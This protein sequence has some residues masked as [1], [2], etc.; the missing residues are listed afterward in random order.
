MSDSGFSLEMLQLFIPMRR[1]ESRLAGDRSR[2][3]SAKSGSA[4]ASMK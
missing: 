3:F 1:A 4:S 2:A